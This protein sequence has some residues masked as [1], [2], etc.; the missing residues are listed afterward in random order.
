MYE[1]LSLCYFATHILMPLFDRLSTKYTFRL[2]RSG[3]RY[4]N[5]TCGY[6]RNLTK[7]E[8]QTEKGLPDFQH[9]PH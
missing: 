6:T 4:S 5:D 2:R 3:S 8:K 1:S 9:I 7:D